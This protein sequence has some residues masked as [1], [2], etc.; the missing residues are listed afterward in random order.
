MEYSLHIAILTG[1]Y[2]ILAV[3]LNLIAGYA[4]ML[5]IAHAA[6]YG[7]GAYVT[8]LMALKLHTGFW[9]NI[10]C[11]VLFTGM[12]GGLISLPALRIRD[13]YLAVAT[14]GF[15][16]IAFS[17]FNN[18][19]EVTGGSQGLPGIPPPILLGQEITSKDR[20]LLLTLICSAVVVAIA[21]RITHSPF[22]RVLQAIR[23]DEVF[24]LS[25]GKPVTT[26]KMLVF[27]IGA[28]MAAI[29][30]CLYAYYV[31]YIDPTSF[32]VTESIFIISIVT[33]GGFGNIW[34]SIFGAL[35]LVVFPELLRFVGLPIAIAANIRQI[36]YGGLLVGLMVWRSVNVS[37]Q[38]SLESIG[39]RKME[40]EKT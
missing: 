22:G 40:N 8:A 10:L 16:V 27:S 36:L 18:W 23:E 33:I 14:F 2:T 37:T 19:T 25:L 15:Q 39:R 12:L 35:I 17:I 5:S 30:G 26:Y 6:F 20:F 32:T 7:V 34:G 9:L 38:P 29:A 13:D 4:G 21:Y 11:S 31:R 3:S 24:A 1:I 28:S